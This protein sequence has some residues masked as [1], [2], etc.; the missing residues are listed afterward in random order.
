MFF[1]MRD[2]TLPFLY[3][4]TFEFQL[5]YYL[6]GREV[7]APIKRRSSDVKHTK[8]FFCIDDLLIFL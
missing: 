7:I 8:V 2:I 4:F 6:I 1:V 5:C 3:S